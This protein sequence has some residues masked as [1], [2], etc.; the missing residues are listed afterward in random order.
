MS[1]KS[2]I[3][4]HNT[5]TAGLQYRSVVLLS[6]LNI[7]H[8]LPAELLHLIAR[9]AARHLFINH[10]APYVHHPELNHPQLTKHSHNLEIQA[11]ARSP[12]RNW[13][14]APAHSCPTHAI[15]QIRSYPP[16]FFLDNRDSCAC[17]GGHDIKGIQR[18]L[19]HPLHVDSKSW[20]RVASRCQQPRIEHDEIERR[21]RHRPAVR[22][23]RDASSRRAN[24][25]RG[26]FFS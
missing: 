18:T 14:K 1:T 11:K 26:K 17:S 19:V 13:S 25:R 10:H 2:N 9:R 21:H 4:T 5:S 7:S 12:S 23:I 8:V 16:P 3:Y 22:C 24:D 15:H 6:T 20:C